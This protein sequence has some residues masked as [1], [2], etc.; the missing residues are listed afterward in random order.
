M[1]VLVVAPVRSVKAARELVGAGET[2]GGP[3]IVVCLGPNAAAAVPDF[4]SSGADEVL[5]WDEPALAATSGEAALAALVTACE[6][7]R[8]EVVLLTGDSAGRDW[9]PRL[10]WRLGAGLVTEC[11]G[12]E[13]GPDGRLHFQRPVYGGKAVAT[14]AS[15]CPIQMAVVQPGSF[16]APEFAP[17]RQGTVRRLEVAAVPAE[18]WPR[19]LERVAEAA[20][21]PGLEN[22]SIVI[23][24]G[25]GLGGA[26][27][28]TLLK[29]LAD[30]LG[31]AVGASRAAVDEGWAPSSWQIGQTGKAVRPDLYVAVGISGASQ[32]MAGVAGAKTI[33]AIN[34]DKDAPIFASARLGVVG[35]YRQVLP[36]L[37]AALRE[38]LGQ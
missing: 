10:A 29:E 4:L 1:K 9:A 37:I 8:P 27:N 25:R 38:L 6:E 16:A 33:V 5:W 19:V 32:H 23:A 22:A 18:S 7:I 36:A 2:L 35:D 28:F 14:I 11:T 26:E 21:G 34:T 15:R 3:V 24:G 20:A 31:A 13:A 30:V 12:W 17:G